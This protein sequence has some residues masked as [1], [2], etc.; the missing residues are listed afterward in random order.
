[1]PQAIYKAISDVLKDVGA[2]GKDG[3][4]TFD[5]YNYRS[6]DAVMNAMHPA[7]ANHGVFVSPEVLEMTREERQSANG[8]TLIYSMAKVR[9]TFFAEDGSSVTATVIGEGMDRGDKSINKAM[10]AAFKYALFQ[11]FCIPTEEMVD[12][13][14]DSPAVS[15]R[16]PAAQKSV[17]HTQQT[18]Q[19]SQQRTVPQQTGQTV[20]QQTAQPQQIGPVT[21]ET[22]RR[23]VQDQ[24]Q[25]PQQTM[26]DL[27][28]DVEL[29]TL[30]ATIHKLWPKRTIESIF[31]KWPN[32]TRQQ[33]GEFNQTVRNMQNKGK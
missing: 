14:Q 21:N 18:Q 24:P 30:E 1:M 19:A 33:Y 15:D 23:A 32:V 5:K 11:V 20:P 10:S 26:N 16:K 4:N 8:N 3:K 25:E 7:M 27:C 12:S 28:N 22:I 2:V 31:P 29:A 6:I 9:Y 13:E 17:Q